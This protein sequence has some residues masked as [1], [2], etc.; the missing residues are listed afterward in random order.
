[1]AVI[2][3][4]DQQTIDQIA[5]GE[6][7]ERPAS[8]AKEL[9]ENSI[10]AGAQKITIEIKEG[11]ISFIRIS[12]DGC[13][14]SREDLPVAFLRH[15]TSKLR[16]AQDLSRI[17]SLGFRGEAL[18][19]I[20]AI[21]HTEV[22]TKTAAQ[23][24]ASLYRIEGGKEV[25]LTD[26]AAPQGTTF[27]VRQL[28]YNV[29]A[30]RKFLKTPSTEAGHIYDTIL[31]LALS[32]PEV[33]FS[34]ISEGR[35]RLETVGS[36]KMDD[37]IYRLFGR[38]AAKGLIP[39]EKHDVG[40]TGLSLHGMIGRPETTRAN[41]SYEFFFVNGRYIKSPLLSKALEEGYR[42]YAMQH[43]FPFAVIYIRSEADGVDVNVHPTKMEVR[44]ARQNDVFAL[45]KRAVYEAMQEPE[46]I[47][48]VQ[49]DRPANP[50]SPSA[51]KQPGASAFVLPAS[52]QPGASVFA[53][54]GAA[55]P[56][57]NVSQPM[58]EDYFMQQMRKR[59]QAYHNRTSSAETTGSSDLFRPEERTDM[60]RERA[61]IAR[62]AA[63]SDPPA[64]PSSAYPMRTQTD[65]AKTLEPDTPS[66]L[67]PEEDGQLRFLRQDDRPDYK[68]IGQAFDT[69]WILQYKDSLYIIDQH[70]A[71][72]K[73][74]YERT[75]RQ[76]SAREHVSQYISPPAIVHVTMREKN[77]LET[78]RMDFE[79]VG[80]V[81]EEFGDDAYSICAVPANLFG[82]S[83]K[84][85]F[86]QMLDELADTM[87]SGRTGETVLDK[88]ASISC[89]AA[90]KGNH[91]MSSRE[92]HAL[93]DELFLLDNPFHCP[94]G[95]PTMI[96][97]S[98][99]ELE[100]K[101]RRIV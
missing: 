95:R 72:E 30:R 11:G 69:Y 93:M 1:M 86:T 83:D 46:L 40:E 33:A 12:D 94:H 54:S 57:Q 90:V 29:P 88:I 26:A 7:I 100:K 23:D 50:P 48:S 89:K 98:K 66:P 84:E 87:Q 45:I 53:P 18:S 34:F 78:F 79:R 55:Q 9:V 59:V 64:P 16:S 39:F 6:V 43:R 21:S 15:A 62:Q 60:I 85:L 31:R 75:L 82:L 70:A 51:A 73:V 41:R 81:I 37:V 96:A 13:G 52:S 27:T 24:A 42:E 67:A 47:P 74:L 71:H 28:F 10:D 68:I 17:Q 61:Q 2:H 77:V 8:I 97:M 14:I 22:L 101:F 49:L 25:S 38:E 65:S 92:L 80:F 19:S 76:M 36:G 4:L 32:H 20:A 56:V 58:D 5:A 35:Q 63:Q 3:V 91:A 99:R 44:F